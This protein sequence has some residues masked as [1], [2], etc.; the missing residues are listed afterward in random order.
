M[1]CIHLDGY[2]QFG[3]CSPMFCGSMVL[4]LW[5][6]VSYSIVYI[7]RDDRKYFITNERN[8]MIC[9][10]LPIFNNFFNQEK[11]LSAR[12]TSAY[13]S[14]HFRGHVHDLG[15]VESIHRKCIGGISFRRGAHKRSGGRSLHNLSQAACEVNPISSCGTSVSDVCSH[16]FSIETSLQSLT[17]IPIRHRKDCNIST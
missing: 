1:K 17:C 2:N 16:Q 11:A 6:A 9:K 15:R 3:L 13:E 7:C 14:V 12:A 5:L 8:R 10:S 4:Y